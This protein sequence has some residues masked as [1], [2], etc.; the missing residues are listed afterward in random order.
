MTRRIGLTL[1]G[2]LLVL[3]PLAG[4]ASAQNY[5]PADEGQQVSD[6]Q[7]TP[8]EPFTVSG[9]GFAPG[10]DVTVRFDAQVLGTVLVRPNGTFSGQFTTPQNA[11]PG[12]HTIS[13]TGRAPDGTQRVLRTTVQVL[14]AAGAPQRAGTL[15]RTGTGLTMPLATSAGLLIGAGAVAIVATRRRRQSA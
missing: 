7:L 6:T 8:G 14:A 5:P 10:S 15:P 4:A 2:V 1:A 3:L 11:T 12:T 9:G 13:S